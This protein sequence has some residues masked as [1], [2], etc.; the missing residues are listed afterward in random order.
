M[1]SLRFLTFYKAI[2]KKLAEY[3]GVS[4]LNVILISGFSSKNKVF[5]IKTDKINKQNQQTEVG[6]PL[7]CFNPSNERIFKSA[8]VTYWK[9]DKIKIK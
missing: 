4:I 9:V 6:L 5:E 8:E 2:I 3:F 7:V 1:H